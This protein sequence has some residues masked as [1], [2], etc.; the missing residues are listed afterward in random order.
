[1]AIPPIREGRLAVRVP[2]WL[3]DSVMA[4]P[5][6]R[7]LAEAFPELQVEVWCRPY[8]ADLWRM[9]PG[10]E[11]VFEAEDK[12]LSGPFRIALQ[13]RKRRYQ[14][15]LL[16]TKSWRT[17]LGVAMAGIPV[18]IGD[19][20]GES[21]FLLTRTVDV[22]RDGHQVDRYLAL[23]SAL[24]A[25]LQL[26]PR[27]NL[28]I[29]PPTLTNIL[30]RMNGVVPMAGSTGAWVAIHPSAA[31]GNAKRWPQ[32]RYA[33]LSETLVR[34]HGVRVVFIGAPNE[35]ECGRFLAEHMDR[36]WPH[37]QWGLNLVGK[38]TLPELAAVIGQ[39]DLAI[40]NDSGPMHLA[41][42]I[43]TPVLTLFGPT[44]SEETGPWGEVGEVIDLKLDCAPCM[45]RECPLDH[46]CML[47]ITPQMVVDRALR[48]L[49]Q[50]GAPRAR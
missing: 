39:C 4:I 35:E 17:T 29:P 16:M 20:Q 2:N 40:G 32:D 11:Q 36:H 25:D 42:A 21:R 49:A 19:R 48:I 44:K 31:F 15:A 34:K 3:G 12:G 8:L 23:A 14:A 30:D 26:R 1:M 24:G 37:G 38:T 41:S 18:R 27:G 22:P 5:S 50:S 47:G 28:R 13:L 6:I 10:V 46:G 43:G 7:G 45:R 33:I 9:V